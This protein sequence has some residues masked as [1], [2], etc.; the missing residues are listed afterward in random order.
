MLE[1][2][3]ACA[4]Q[5]LYGHQSDLVL[6]ASWIGSLPTRCVALCMVVELS[7]MFGST[8]TAARSP[9]CISRVSCNAVLASHW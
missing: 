7:C 3:A 5:G 9:T 2:I 6:T 4:A 1:T 8:Q